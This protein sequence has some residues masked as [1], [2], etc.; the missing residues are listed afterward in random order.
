MKPQELVR[1]MD[2]QQKTRKLVG[3]VPKL[4]EVEQWQ[5]ELRAPA[6]AHAK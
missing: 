4:V 2:E 6:F 1:L 3:G 5:N